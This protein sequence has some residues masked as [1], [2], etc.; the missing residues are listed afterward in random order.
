MLTLGPL[1]GDCGGLGGIPPRR[2]PVGGVR[3]RSGVI[4]ELEVLRSSDSSDSRLKLGDRKPSSS[5]EPG[6]RSRMSL[7]SSKMATPP[8][9]RLGYRIWASSQRQS[10]KSGHASFNFK[11][12]TFLMGACGFL[13]C[14]AMS[15]KMSSVWMEVRETAPYSG[16]AFKR[17]Y[18]CQGES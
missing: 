8:I 9:G 16:E 4:S 13:E 7:I 10:K 14:L 6:G 2:F 18:S 15:A 11:A 1:A 12:G 17:L 5:G 3:T